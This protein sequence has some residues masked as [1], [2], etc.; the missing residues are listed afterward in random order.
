[1]AKKIRLTTFWEGLPF[2]NYLYFSLA[3]NAVTGLIIFG[4]FN[5]LPPLLPLFYGQPEG[6]S[7]LVPKPEVLIAP[8][9][10]ILITAVNITLARLIKNKFI[11]KILLVSSFFV[12]LLITITVIK[13][14]LLVGFF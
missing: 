9:V 12:S 8:L 3:L 10:A 5:F 13:I 11:Q 14:T 7:Q 1:M 2:K 6:Q 4:G